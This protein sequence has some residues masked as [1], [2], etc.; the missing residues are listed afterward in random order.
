MSSFGEKAKCS[1]ERL[2]QLPFVN[3]S[4]VLE[5]EFELLEYELRPLARGVRVSFFKELQHI[6]DEAGHIQHI[7]TDGVEKLAPSIETIRK[8]YGRICE[9]K[10]V[11]VASLP[12][13]PSETV[14]APITSR[15][16]TTTGIGATSP[17]VGVVSAVS[18]PQPGR[19]PGGVVEKITPDWKWIDNLNRLSSGSDDWTEQDERIWA[20]MMQVCDENFINIKQ[21]FTSSIRF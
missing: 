21:N 2:S 13:S 19:V 18:Q 16:D 17:K 8:T 7:Q 11:K 4:A 1:I 14:S 20:Y 15:I 5:S 3:L 9:K 12:H 10:G 6:L